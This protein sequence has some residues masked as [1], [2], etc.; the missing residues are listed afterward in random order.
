MK[1]DFE[2]AK[3]IDG[4]LEEINGWKVRDFKMWEKKDGTPMATIR[5]QKETEK[6][7]A[8]NSHDKVRRNLEHIHKDRI[9]DDS[10]S[11]QEFT[12]GKGETIKDALEKN[13]EQ[14]DS[15]YSE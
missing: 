8:K 14:G 5:L 11:V 3:K 4:K 1:V 10:S 2:E 13:V 15:V 12:I 7:N 6:E 9:D